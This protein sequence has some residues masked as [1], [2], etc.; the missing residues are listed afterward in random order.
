MVRKNVPHSITRNFRLPIQKIMQTTATFD[1]GG[2]GSHHFPDGGRPVHMRDRPRI[3]VRRIQPVPAAARREPAR[4]R[5]PPPIIP[6]QN[7]LQGL[8]VGAD[9]AQDFEFMFAGT[10]EPVV[11][12]YSALGRFVV[13]SEY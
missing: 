5:G 1:K 2:N 12:S 6:D 7:A 3:E 13:D 11:G 9:D 10:S 8:R 4:L